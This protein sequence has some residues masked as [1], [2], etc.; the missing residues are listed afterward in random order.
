MLLDPGDHFHAQQT[1]RSKLQIW[2]GQPRFIIKTVVS[3]VQIPNTV[4]TG[5]A[6]RVAFLSAVETLGCGRGSRRTSNITRAFDR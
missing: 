1:T 2:V 6:L 5:G 4:V 3:P